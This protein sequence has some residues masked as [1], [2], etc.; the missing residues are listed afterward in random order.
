M[1]VMDA[2]DAL[3]LWINFTTLAPVPDLSAPAAFLAKLLPKSLIKRRIMTPRLEY[4]RAFAEHFSGVVAGDTREGRVD[5]H[6]FKSRIG[7]QHA[8]LCG[9]KNGCGLSQQ[10]FVVASLGDITGNPDQTLWLVI[11][12]MQ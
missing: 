1:G 4:C 7:H 12:V 3:P 6:N 5:M 8:F 9:L 2:A 11:V 10:M